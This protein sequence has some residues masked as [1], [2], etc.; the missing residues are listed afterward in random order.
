MK[1]F[2][3]RVCGL[4]L[5][6]S[7]LCAAAVPALAAYTGSYFTEGTIAEGKRSYYYECS[8]KCTTFNAHATT[9][10][11]GSYTTVAEV[12]AYSSDGGFT[13]KRTDP[14]TVSATASVYRPEGID[15]CDCDFLIDNMRIANPRVIPG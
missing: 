2:A 12:I 8:A 14:T 1:K 3:R 15:Y 6:L 7:L 9:S 11:Q 4:G 13:G 5:S 10:Y